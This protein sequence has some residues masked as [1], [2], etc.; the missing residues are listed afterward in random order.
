MPK[1]L[2]RKICK[3]YLPK[4][5][6]KR[7]LN[8]DDCF[9]PPVS[10]IQYLIIEN[11]TGFVFS[12]IFQLEMSATLSRKCFCFMTVM[13]HLINSLYISLAIRRDPQQQEKVGDK[14][15]RQQTRAMLKKTRIRRRVR[16]RIRTGRQ[17]VLR[18]IR[19]RR[20]ANCPAELGLQKSL[21]RNQIE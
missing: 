2:Q 3:I 16:K 8:S 21:K 6:R 4:T 15:W 17:A 14:K 7:L 13:S 12:H 11:S 9:K 5:W 18:K 19:T 1:C 20:R 10:R